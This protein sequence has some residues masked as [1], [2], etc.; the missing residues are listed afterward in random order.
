MSRVGEVVGRVG[1]WALAPVTAAVAAARHSRVFHP[2]GVVFEVVI[3]PTAEDPDLWRLAKRL[4]GT[5]IA[6]LS[7]ALWKG[8]KEW[9]DNLGLALRFGDDQDLLFATIRSP[10]TTV[11]AALRTKFHD[12]LANDF[13]AVSPF[14]VDGIGRVR[15]RLVPGL[16]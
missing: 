1:G 9:I 5:G 14:R 12:F 2:D 10:W 11:L 3:Q 13:Y 16:Y 4:E 6:R 8:D 15:W 7:S